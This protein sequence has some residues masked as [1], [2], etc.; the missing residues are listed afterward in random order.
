MRI[1]TLFIWAFLSFKNTD[2]TKNNYHI[3]TSVK[4]SIL[5][6]CPSKHK[7]NIYNESFHCSLPS[8]CLCL[9]ITNIWYNIR[10]TMGFIQT[11]LWKA[12]CIK[13][14][15]SNTVREE[16]SL[17]SSLFL[18]IVVISIVDQFGKIMLLLLKNTILKLT[19]VYILIH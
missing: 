2:T 16:K 11:H 12:I 13:C 5:H 4:F 19:S 7:L 18:I 3:Y 9:L 8:F 6:C 17:F 14:R 1:I 10:C 15:R